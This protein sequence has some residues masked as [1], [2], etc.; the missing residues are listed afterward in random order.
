M[1]LQK[2]AEENARKNMFREWKDDGRGIMMI[3][4]MGSGGR[5]SEAVEYRQQDDLTHDLM[6]KLLQ[7]LT[8]FLPR[9]DSSSSFDKHPPLQ[10]FTI[11][12]LSLLL[13]SVTA[14]IGNDSIADMS[15]RSEL[16]KA[17]LAFVTAAAK[18]PELVKILTEKRPEKKMSPGLQALDEESTPSAFVFDTS[19]SGM[20]AS[21]AACSGS[22][23]KQAKA[24]ASL[25]SKPAMASELLGNRTSISICKR[26]LEFREVLKRTAPDAIRS[27]FANSANAWTVY[28]EANKVTFTDD[29]LKDHKFT[30]DFNSIRQNPPGRMAHLWKEIANLSTSLPEGIFLKVAERRPDVMKVLIVGAK[31]SPYAWG[32]VHVSP[33]VIYIVKCL[34]MSNLDSTCT[35]PKNWPQVPPIFYIDLDE[36]STVAGYLN[37]NIH[38]DGKGKSSLPKFRTYRPTAPCSKVH[39]QYA[40]VYSTPGWPTTPPSP[41]NPTNP[42]SSPSSSPCKP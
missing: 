36:G 42:P 1:Q 7:L 11:L 33:L 37:P 3:R 40:S 22:T 32:V 26:I 14:L 24:F 9:A 8:A 34:L 18:Y 4:R 29:V 5:S 41:G 30:K 27:L 35:L 25:A 28:T 39:L 20:S 6:G 38:G 31:G 15:K 16:H 12:R 21:L 23:F 19:R 10:L 2:R 17:L 13:E